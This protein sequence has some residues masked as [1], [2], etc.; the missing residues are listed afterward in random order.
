[1]VSG[2]CVVWLCNY[3]CLTHSCFAV[4]LYVCVCVAFVL[5][6][7]VPVNVCVGHICLCCLAVCLYVSVEHKFYVVWLY[8]CMCVYA[9][10]VFSTTL[11]L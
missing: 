6:G 8:A 4:C 2:T 3:M 9:N 5:F 1:M 10:I 7:C 11:T